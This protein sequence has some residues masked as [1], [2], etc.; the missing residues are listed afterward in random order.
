MAGR[1]LA[2]VKPHVHCTARAGTGNW[3]RC[4]AGRLLAGRG[5][6]CLRANHARSRR[7]CR[8]NWRADEFQRL[9]RMPPVAMF[10]E[11]H[12]SHAK[13]PEVLRYDFGCFV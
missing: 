13:G 12:L 5:D 6:T 11:H 9:H 3:G 8:A 2:D 7:S 4:A 1:L 10:T